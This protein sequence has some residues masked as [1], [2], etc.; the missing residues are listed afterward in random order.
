MAMKRRFVIACAL[1]AMAFTATTAQAADKP[2]IKIGLLLP[3]TGVVASYGIMYRAAFN[4]AVDDINN[5]GGINGSKIEMLLEDDRQ[6]PSESVLLF[7]KVVS[8]GAVAVL[9]PISGGSWE[10]ASPLANSLKTPA[11]NWT[12]LKPGLTQK[13]YA[14][15][16][17]PPDD[18]MVP[19]GVAEFLKKFPQ[20]KKVIIAG[21]LKE[22]SGESGVEQ[23][24]KAAQAHGLQ[25]LDVIGYQ[26]TTS[27][28][29]PIVIKMR[30]D[31][32]DAVLVSS[33]TPTTLALAKEMETQGFDK[34]VLANAL[35]WAGAFPQAV[36]S[37]GKNIYTIG[38]NT[39]EP[40][41]EIKGHDEFVARYVKVAAE[42][43]QLPRPANVCNTT[44][45]YDTV[46]LLAKILREK[47]ID[48]ATPP[49]EARAAIKDGLSE[50][51]R[52]Q[53]FNTITMR[54]TGDGHIQ[55][56]LLAVDVDGKQWKYALPPSER[57]NTPAL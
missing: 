37:A 52:W 4:L 25:V 5:A 40:A 7:R 12:A 50:I 16:L 42:T 24:K 51:K 19:E 39:N 44:L 3:L 2:P 11:L 32:P 46:T 57:I 13:P 33:F 27:D 45:A 8:E 23:F 22:A 30:G 15:R 56:H 41:P 29:S 47:H 54:D 48:G 21:D 28:F 17:H 20:V 49:E 6:V 1:A 43:T 35:I 18:T 38:F 26:T 53:G 14:L 34:P 9:G 36:G 31:A 55:S 10:N